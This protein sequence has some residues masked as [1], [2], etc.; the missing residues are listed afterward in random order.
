[1]GIGFAFAVS[2]IANSVLGQNLLDVTIS[3]PLEFLSIGFAFIMGLASG[4]LPAL[5]ASQLKPVVALRG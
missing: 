5:Q 3:Y 1:M 2:A 4:I